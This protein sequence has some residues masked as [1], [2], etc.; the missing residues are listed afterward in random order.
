MK[1]AF[2]YAARTWGMYV[3]MVLLSL[4]FLAGTGT[5]WLMLVLD[6]AML[7]AFGL[8]I[9]SEG[10]Y[11]G[12]KGCTLDATLERQIKEGRRV[13]E[14]QREY[15]FSKK[16]AVRT[17][18]ICL[19]PFLIVA[20]LNL[21]VA[22]FYP[23]AEVVE[24]E[25]EAFTYDY[26]AAEK[27]A[28]TPVNW[29][30]I[31]ARTVFMPYVGSYTLVDSGTLNWLFLLYSFIMPLCSFAGYLTGPKMRQK[32]LRDI[33]LGKKRKQRNLK[34]NRQRSQRGPKAEV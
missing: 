8:L 32:K 10:A 27:A 28:N 7:I 5:T 4:I 1:V 16:T 21:I 13:D 15:G 11:N 25:R 24:T 6:A 3:V 23:E 14:S 17:L 30:N 29:V 20:V 31:A 33:A 26:E 18:I 12:E 2:S 22:P 19:A 9:F 34:V